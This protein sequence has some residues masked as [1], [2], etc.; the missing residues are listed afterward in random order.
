[1]W[2]LFRNERLDLDSLIVASYAAGDSPK[3]PVERVMAFLTRPLCGIVLDHQ[4]F[5]K[6][7]N[8]KGSS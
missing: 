4:K 2:G 8:A 3:N 5:G 6:H 1:M 7:M